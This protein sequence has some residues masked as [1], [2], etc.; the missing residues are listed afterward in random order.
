MASNNACVI[1]IPEILAGKIILLMIGTH[2]KFS[3]K[4]K[5][6]LVIK[7]FADLQRLHENVKHN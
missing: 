2:V 7:H 6:K 5:K 1:L 3:D 4:K